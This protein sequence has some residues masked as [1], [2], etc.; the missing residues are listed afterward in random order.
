VYCISVLYFDIQLHFG[1]LLLNGSMYCSIAYQCENIFSALLHEA[2]L[3][4]YID[5]GISRPAILLKAM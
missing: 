2:V 1:I 3:H 5:D 4:I